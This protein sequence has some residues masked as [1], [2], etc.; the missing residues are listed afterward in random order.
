MG[1]GLN[2]KR[3][4]ARVTLLLEIASLRPPNQ[5][6]CDLFNPFPIPSASQLSRLTAQFLFR[7]EALYFPFVSVAPSL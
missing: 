7:R 3:R 2:E 6:R 4:P 1:G 5:K